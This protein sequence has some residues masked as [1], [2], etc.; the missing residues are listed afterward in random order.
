[1]E[2][3]KRTVTQYCYGKRLY[4]SNATGNDGSSSNNPITNFLMSLLILSSLLL[5]SDP[6]S[7]HFQSS[8]SCMYLP[9]HPIRNI[10]P[11][12]FKLLELI[13]HVYPAFLRSW[14]SAV[15]IA[16]GYGLDDTGVGVRVPVGSRIFSSPC[17][18]DRLWGSLSL[19]SKAYRGL[20]PWG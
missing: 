16:I 1:M 8:V 11:N 19:I 13:Y 14:D 2:L 20:L 5:L 9:F 10:W 15:D 3:I 17:R 18:P 7:A 6:S 4:A 12:C